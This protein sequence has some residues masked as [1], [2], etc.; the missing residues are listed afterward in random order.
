MTLPDGD[1][2]KGK[3]GQEKSYAADFIAGIRA[4]IALPQFFKLLRKRSI[5]SPKCLYQLPDV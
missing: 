4:P 5:V 2:H 1:Q 3:N